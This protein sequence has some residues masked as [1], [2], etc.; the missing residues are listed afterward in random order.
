MK[1]YQ[2]NADQVIAKATQCAGPALPSPG[3]SE[4]YDLDTP[5]AGLPQEYSLCWAPLNANGS[6]PRQRLG[7]LGL[8]GPWVSNVTTAHANPRQNS[9]N[10]V[11]RGIVCTE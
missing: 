7:T 4:R 6:M 8:V 5:V 1:R 10:E 11:G 2:R 9:T 3:R